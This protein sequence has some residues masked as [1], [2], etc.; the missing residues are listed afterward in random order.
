MTWSCNPDAQRDSKLSC[1]ERENASFCSS[2]QTSALKLPPIQSST[3]R[4]NIN[5]VEAGLFPHAPSLGKG[6]H[7]ESL[8]MHFVLFCYFASTINHW[9]Y[10]IIFLSSFPTSSK[11]TPINQPIFFFIHDFVDDDDGGG[12][13]DDDN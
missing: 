2:G 9:P 12:D 10:P 3:L 13:D 6:K 7:T 11:A 5:N 4:S 1:T 8:T